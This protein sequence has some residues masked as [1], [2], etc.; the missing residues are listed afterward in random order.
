MT[1]SVDLSRK[2]R[3]QISFVASRWEVR[4]VGRSC[5]LQVQLQAALRLRI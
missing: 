5:R 1:F 4:W 3:F 2:E